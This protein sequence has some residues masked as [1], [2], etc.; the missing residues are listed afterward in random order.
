MSNGV[1]TTADCSVCKFIWPDSTCHAHPPGAVTGLM[2]MTAPTWVWP[3][4]ASDDW[5]GE[6]QQAA[7]T[8]SSPPATVSAPP[9]IITAPV[10]TGNAAQP[11]IC[12]CSQG[13]WSSD[14]ISFTYQ[15]ASAGVDIAGATGNYYQT[16]A[17]DVGNL[18]TCTV[19]A[20]NSFGP[21]SAIS[22]NQ[23]GPVV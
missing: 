3:V 9:T 22:S 1:S 6:F 21:A 11:A 12:M 15:W 23:I 10:V 4:V 20:Q 2:G 5:C 19:T 8:P 18:V 16:A 13:V 17:S 7:A 14:A